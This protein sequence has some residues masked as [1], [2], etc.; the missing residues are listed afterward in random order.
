ML[1]LG[2]INET[3]VRLSN[4]S[5]WSRPVCNAEQ[6]IDAKGYDL[7]KYCNEERQLLKE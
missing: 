7:T 2:Q 6:Q 4:R 3:D 1:S 5:S